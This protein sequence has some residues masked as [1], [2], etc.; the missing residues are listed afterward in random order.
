HT[1]WHVQVQALSAIPSVIDQN[2]YKE[3]TVSLKGLINKKDSLTAPYAAFIAH[4]I[5]QYDGEAA[6]GILDSLIKIYPKNKFVADAIISNLQEK[7][8]SFLASIKSNNTN[9]NTSIIEHLETVILDIKKSKDDVNT[10]RAQETYPKGA[11]IF[12]ANCMACH[13][14][15]GYGI[16]A[17]APPLNNSNWVNGDK[18]KLIATVLYGLSGSILV[19]G[20]PMSFASE[21]PGIGQNSQFSNK[22]IAQTLSFVRSAWSNN[23][24]EISE[25][26]VEKIREKF[27]D[28]EKA[29]TMPELNSYWD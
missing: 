22:D 3:F 17:L 20:E 7:E 21:M 26:E 11:A 15:D 23:A 29:F 16:E 6:N 1:D 28:R 13:G 25:E 19:N 24:S 9:I 18:R 4:N 8:D 14:R 27:K 10:A 2:N 12:K 5:R